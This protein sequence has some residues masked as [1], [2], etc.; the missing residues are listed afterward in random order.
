MSRWPKVHTEEVEHVLEDEEERA[1][2]AAER[3]ELLD[4]LEQ[5]RDGVDAAALLA[6]T[7]R[8]Q[9][10]KER[11]RRAK[12]REARERAVASASVPRARV[13]VQAVPD[14]PHIPIRDDWYSYDD[15]YV[16]RAG[17]YYD[18]ISE[19]VRRDKEGIMRAGGYIIEEAWERA[20]RCAV[21]GLDLQP[22]K[23]SNPQLTSLENP[24][25]SSTN[26]EDVV[27]AGT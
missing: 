4:K 12:E 1:A 20:L 2:R 26:S 3:A 9:R 13:N 19:A 5:S 22:L 10:E 18:P 15:K 21:A 11:E 6:E 8:R 27:M 23:G 25:T 7:T 14:T 24:L 16:L 17:G